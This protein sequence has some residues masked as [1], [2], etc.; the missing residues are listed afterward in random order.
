MG[1]GLK[2][3][4]VPQIEAKPKK[5]NPPPPQRTHE[6]VIALV[7]SSQNKPVVELQKPKVVKVKKL[8][9]IDVGHGHGPY[10][11]DNRGGN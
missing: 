7:K 5:N 9:K 4:R 10:P 11:D 8:P 6:E 1:E 2:M 3:G